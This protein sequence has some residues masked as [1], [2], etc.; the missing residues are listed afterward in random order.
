[1][2][3]RSIEGMVVDPE[4][5]SIFPAR[6][7]FSDVIEEIKRL[8]GTKGHYIL[9]GFIDAHVHIESS[10]LLPSRFAKVAVPH[11]TVAVV[12]D[13]HEIANVLGVKGIKYLIRDAEG[14]PLRFYFTAPSCVPATEFE[15]SG[16]SLGEREIEELLSMEKIVAL[17]EMMNFPG[18][19]N[20]IPEVMRKIEIARKMGK[21]VDGHAPGLMG[22]DIKKYFGA[23]ITTDHECLSLAEAIEKAEEGVNIMVREGSSAKNLEAL[24]R[25]SERFEVFL[26]TDDIGPEDLLE[27]HLDSLLNRALSLG[28]NFFKA[29]RA[30]TA[31]PSKHYNLPTGRMKEGMKA[32]FILMDGMERISVKEVYI[33]GK[34]VARNGKALFKLP[35]ARPINRFMV[36]GLKKEDFIV[37]ARGKDEVSVRVISAQDGSL[38]T[39]ESVVTL[40]VMDGKVLS[41]PAED[42]LKIAVVERYGKGNIANGYIKGFG[43]K[44]GAIAS[45]IAHDSHNILAVGVDEDSI[46]AAVKEIVRMK[47]GLCAVK[48]KKV[49]TLPLKIAGLL[50]EEDG[51]R[52]AMKLKK[53]TSFVK[54]ELGCRLSNPFGTL[55][56]MALLV[57]PELKMSD[58]GLFDG[59]RFQFTEVII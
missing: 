6:I 23:G 42:I 8:S 46:L 38:F 17:G 54:E 15:T 24:W 45:S 32:D 4:L 39:E 40:K 26:V 48:G 7:Y 18:V 25:V 21:P 28:M 1:M 12:S 49:L 11:G 56:F 27:G 33:D 52:V 36:K 58:R 37:Q 59:R 3:V 53:L 5:E 44:A 20:R 34:R 50:S 10:M 30:V 47:G 35:P 51:K 43:L 31:N 55:S 9:P 13:P 14:V 22:E 57:I 19:L 29:L 16:A 41:S 2:K